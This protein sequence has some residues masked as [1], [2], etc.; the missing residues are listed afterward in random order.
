MNKNF[1]ILILIII[2]LIITIIIQLIGIN[3]LLNENIFKSINLDFESN[4]FCQNIKNISNNNN[5]DHFICDNK[6][7]KE[8]IIFLLIDSLPFDQLNDFHN[9]KKY[10]MTNFF[11]VKGLE[12]KQ[13]GALFETILT[14]KFS[15]NYLAS[16]EMK[17]DNL[18]KQFNNANLDI[19]YRI[20]NFPLYGLFNKTLIDK[21][22]LDKEYKEKFPLIECCDINI[23]P[24][25]N[26]GKEIL[27]N[28]LDDSGL[29][30]KKGMNK[31]ILYKM[32]DEKLKNEFKKIRKNF[33]NSFSKR[34][35]S[36][37][38]YFSDKLDF[39]SHNTHRSFPLNIY[40]IYIIEKLIKELINWINEE[41]GEYALVFVSDHG[42]QLYYGED[43]LCNHGCN[44]LGNEGVF[45]IYT[46]ELGENYEKYKTNIEKEEIPI[47][48]LNDFACTLTQ[49]LKYTNLPL[50]SICTP[51][52]IGN[53]KLIFFSSV[54]SKEIQLKK[55]IEKLI[56]KYPELKYQYQQ[57]YDKKLNNNKFNSYFK[58]FNSIYQAEDKFYDDYMK[59]LIDI[60]QELFND[61]V[62]SGQN[63]F[64]FFTF[65]LVL[66]LFILVLLYYIR[67]LILLTKEKVYK[68]MKNNSILKKIVSYIYII[69]IILLIEPIFCLIYNNSLNISYYIRISIF[70]K[71]FSLLFLVII[72]S[73]L[74]KFNRNNYT[75]LIINI[76]FIIF[77][78][79]VSSKIELFSSL[80]KYV[81]TQ[82][83]NDFIKIYLSYPL[84]IIYVCMELYSDRNY[85]YI[86][87]K[88][89]IRYIYIVIPYIIILSYYISSFDFYI[90][91]RRYKGHTPEEINILKKIYR[92]IF[93]LLLFI[94]PFN[95][96]IK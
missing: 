57:K 20:K 31:D 52:N 92:M 64:F 43:T 12:Y 68:E 41:H 58:D 25:V 24:F 89:K 61:E 90:K 23:Q 60:Q 72:I 29:Y 54:K 44:S 5:L 4:D 77:L 48:S 35:F 87:K 37:Y 30:F 8:K 16:K 66:T 2:K 47:V 96:K 85:Y 80:D 79:L 62:K 28:Y 18:Q 3:I 42:G 69:I 86:F 21:K 83:R 67:K 94:K 15:R 70:I 45:F 32:A 91:I 51:R 38:I 14:G 27:F 34:N 63:K 22:K 39:L 78:N 1:K 19:F 17:M 10:N 59:Y 56:K 40:C 50:E 13:S 95:I 81:N 76:A 93:L 33:T 46:K 75:K 73:Y 11:R 74:N 6:F 26:F 49:A 55:Y 65:Y 88:F 82:K 84:F 53:D 7:K 36:S 9:L 71:F